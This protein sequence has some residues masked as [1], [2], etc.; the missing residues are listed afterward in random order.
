MINLPHSKGNQL[1]LLYLEL[2]FNQVIIE[3]NYCVGKLDVFQLKSEIDSRHVHK[4]RFMNK[5]VMLS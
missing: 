4:N 2:V 5:R 1:V 3:L